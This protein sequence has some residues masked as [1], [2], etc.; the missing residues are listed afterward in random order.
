MEEY[1]GDENWANTHSPPPE[2]CSLYVTEDKARARRA[3]TCYVQMSQSW[4]RSETVTQITS[5]LHCLLYILQPLVQCRDDFMFQWMVQCDYERGNRWKIL[6]FMVLNS[7]S[8]CDKSLLCHEKVSNVIKYHKM[9]LLWPAAPCHGEVRGQRIHLCLSWHRRHDRTPVS[10][11][12]KMEITS[13]ICRH[14]SSWFTLKFGLSFKS[15]KK[16][17]DDEK[18]VEY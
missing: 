15:D 2:L 5:Q 12:A 7:R 1:S 18:A 14:L 3:G 13:I 10:R 9:W 17:T 4:E 16:A 6:E 11:L 8:W